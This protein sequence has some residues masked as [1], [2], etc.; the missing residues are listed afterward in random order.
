MIYYTNAIIYFISTHV[1]LTRESRSSASSDE[2]EEKQYHI[3][4]GSFD[5]NSWIILTSCF[6]FFRVQAFSRDY[7]KTLKISYKS[8][9]SSFQKFLFH[10]KNNIS[11]YIIV[12][13]V[14]HTCL[15]LSSCTTATMTMKRIHMCDSCVP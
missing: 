15:Q 7:C 13:H 4:Y 2:S 5:T 9:L 6:L 12:V 10:Q 8:S 14:A 1:K 11:H 3:L